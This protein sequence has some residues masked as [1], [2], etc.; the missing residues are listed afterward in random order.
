MWVSTVPPILL[1]VVFKIW[2]DRTFYDKFMYYIP[3]E[4]ELHQAKIHSSRA[5]DS[6]NRLEKRFGHPALHKE[7]FTPMLH[8]KMMPLLADV[9]KGKIGNDKAR[10]DEYGGQKADA[11]VIEGGLRIAGIEQR[12]LEYDPA[13]YRRDRGELDWDARSVASVAI[14]GHNRGD[15]APAYHQQTHY[16]AGSMAGGRASPAPPA[17]ERYATRTPMNPSN[18]SAIELSQL[19]A[20]VDH[21]PLL[22]D[23][24]VPPLPRYASPDPMSRPPSRYAPPVPQIQTAARF[25][26]SAPPQYPPQ[27]GMQYSPV[28]GYREAPLHRPYL[29]R[30]NLTHHASQESFSSN[31]TGRGYRGGY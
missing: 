5:D 1:V 12:D 4:S 9:Y 10:L 16:H 27:A 6:R 21:L 23:A 7:L 17:F 22:D 3:S 29:S 14:F 15:S 18:L 30:E 19:G 13:L 8:A 20:S 2:L 25:G 24:E 11:R 26:S 28:E 31:P